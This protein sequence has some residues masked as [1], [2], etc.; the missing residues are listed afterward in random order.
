M[1]D[2]LPA[3]LAALL[4]LLTV[5]LWAPPATAQNAE[6][7]DAALA[8][9][10]GDARAAAT[11]SG[12]CQGV[13]TDALLRIYCR[14][15]I[16]V[17]VRKGYPLFGMLEGDSHSGYDVDVARAVAHWLGVTPSFVTVNAADRVSKLVEGRIDLIVATMGHNTQRDGQVRFIRPHYYR[18]ETI[19]VGPRDLEVSDWPDITGRSVCVT[20][21]NGSNAQMVSRGARLMLFDAAGTLPSRLQDGTCTLAAQ[22]DSFFASYLAEPAFASRY[23]Q[24]FGFARVPW[25]M[26]VAPTGAGRLGEALD[27]MSQIFHRDGVFLDLARRNHIRTTFLE[28]QQ[29]L[30]LTPNCNRA[31]GNGD[32]ACV[33]PALDASLKPTRLAAQVVAFEQ[34]VLARTGIPVDLAMLKTRAAWTLFLSGL[35]NS[36]LL[37]TGA[38][39][40]TL[41]FALLFGWMFVCR[42]P[43]LRWLARALTM[44]LQSSPIVLTLVIVASVAQTL[45]VYSTG[46]V[47]GATAVALGLANGCNAGQAISEAVRTLRTERTLAGGAANGQGLFVRAIGRSAMQIISFLVNATKGTPIAAFIGAPE[48]L[49]SLTDITSFASGRETTYALVLVFYILVVMAVMGLFAWLRHWLERSQATA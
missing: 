6:P 32:P 46:V 1:A 17:G 5:A 21:G 30:W 27:L 19:L 45:F 16:R 8:A 38:V 43:P 39:G 31:A 40:A 47:L 13:A 24:K 25:G 28:E 20:I 34:W 10:L 9:L 18:S 37:V 14:G 49:S 3:L 35:A 2:R 41:G 29:A 44:A 33:Q 7:P 23:D 12:A 42:V 4:G 22:D 36:L 15:E 26:A 11:R 48:L